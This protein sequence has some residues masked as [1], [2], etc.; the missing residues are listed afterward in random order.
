MDEL[1]FAPFT[2][3][4]LTGDL[5]G[6]C[7]NILWNCKHPDCDYHY[8]NKDDMV[9]P[10]CNTQRA[11]C[12]NYPRKGRE[13]CGFHGGA[14][15]QGYRHPHYRG[16]GLSKHLP[17]RLLESFELAYEDPE[18]LT[19][20][21]SISLMKA[22]RDDLVSRL[23][24]TPGWEVWQAVRKTFQAYRKAERN[25]RNTGSPKALRLMA[26]K[27]NEL[28]DLILRGNLDA[29]IWREILDLEEKWG[30][31][32]EREHRRLEKIENLITPDQ[33]KTLLRYLIQSVQTHVK[34]RDAINQILLD[35]ERLNWDRKH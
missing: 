13:K 5:L 11:Y 27:L 6:R 8:E 31:M 17:T 21:S 24:E 16:R 3:N 1:E 12:S 22:R 15:L 35:I 20:M 2:P 19:F 10:I 4:N 9:C 23:D 30:R 26:E 32:K 33:F 34:D 18:T 28:E 25:A 14:T 7:N 29:T